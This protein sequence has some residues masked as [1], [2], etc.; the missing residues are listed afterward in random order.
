MMYESDSSLRKRFK[1]EE[2]KITS[3]IHPELDREI[4]SNEATK[5]EEEA[6]PYIKIYFE[7]LSK[8]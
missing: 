1:K 5:F 6:E 4:T 3:Y 7:M 8:K 2:T